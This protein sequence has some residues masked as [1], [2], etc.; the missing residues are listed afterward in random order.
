MAFPLELVGCIA[1]FLASRRPAHDGRRMESRCIP[2]A[3]FRE[4]ST[5]AYPSINKQL[6]Y[7]KRRVRFA[8]KPTLLDYSPARRRVRSQLGE[9][10]T[11]L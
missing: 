7:M 5:R 10:R 6:V 2:I 8:P 1:T 11:K 9:A 4:P 3:I